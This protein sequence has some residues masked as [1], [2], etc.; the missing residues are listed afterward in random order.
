MKVRVRVLDPAGCVI[1]I[2]VLDMDKGPW[3][4][5]YY[6][7][8]A[9]GLHVGRMELEQTDDDAAPGCWVAYDG[10]CLCCGRAVGSAH[11]ERK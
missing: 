1:R 3:T 2:D 5:A 10:L 7:V 4:L 6:P 8:S 9:L 11:D